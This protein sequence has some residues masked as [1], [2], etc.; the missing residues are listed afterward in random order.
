VAVTALALILPI[1]HCRCTVAAHPH[2][3]GWHI[4]RAVNLLTISVGNRGVDDFL[5]NSVSLDGVL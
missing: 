4:K 2:H 3:R 1:A 5:E